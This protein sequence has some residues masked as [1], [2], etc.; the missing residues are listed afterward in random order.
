MY[1]NFCY[2]MHA[3]EHLEKLR[4]RVINWNYNYIDYN[5][6]DRVRIKKERNFRLTLGKRF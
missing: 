6:F 4:L 2:F 1:D 5:Y 3:T